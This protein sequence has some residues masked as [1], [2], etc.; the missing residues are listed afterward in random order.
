M[1]VLNPQL[2]GS[3]GQLHGISLRP[4]LI[5]IP[6]WRESLMQ[7]FSV[8]AIPDFPALECLIQTS[9][10]VPE[11]SSWQSPRSYIFLPIQVH[12]KMPSWSA[13]SHHMEQESFQSSYCLY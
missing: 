10:P 5:L 2:T 12:M 3:S 7:S 6:Q 9:G 4:P 13:P 8:P 11:C 1:Q